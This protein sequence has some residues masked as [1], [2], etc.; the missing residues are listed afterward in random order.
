MKTL[1]RTLTLLALILFQPTVAPAQDAPNSTVDLANSANDLKTLEQFL[2]PTTLIVAQFDMQQLKLPDDLQKSLAENQTAQPLLA[3]LDS[4]KA[5]LEPMSNDR[6]Y[7]TF[8]I[9]ATPTMS[10]IRFFAK[11]SAALDMEKL[12][13]TLAQFRFSPAVVK[14]DFIVTSPAGNIVEDDKNAIT[15]DT[16]TAARPALQEALATVNGMPMQ[17]LLLPPD[18]LWATYRDLMPRLPEQLGGT[19]IATVTEGMKWAAIGIDPA[20]LKVKVTI[21]SNSKAAAAALATELPKLAQ[22]ASGQLPEGSAKTT[23]QAILK[24]GKPTV[25]DDRIEIDFSN[26]SELNLAS[27]AVA[28]LLSAIVDPLNTREKM[29]RFKQL[30]LAVHNYID[31]NKQFP[32]SKEARKADGTSNLSWRVHILPFIGEE[33]LYS[34]FKLDQS[35]DSELNIALL[36][37]MPEIFSGF[38]V[39]AFAPINL[40]QGHTTF[41]A[42]VGEGT[43]FGGVKPVTFSD[44][45]DGTSNTIMF[46][47]VKSDRAV[48]WTAPWDYTFNPANPTSDLAIGADGQFLTAFGDGSV[49]LLPGDM[50]KETLNHLFQMNDGN[51]INF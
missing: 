4:M 32:P 7:M 10:P 39:K 16:L 43:I 36:A 27:T 24:L 19:T 5:S 6:I 37:K 13:Q 15:S 51:A 38:P 28:K 45:T 22:V 31:A 20:K 29:N 35:W 44:I 3:W 2:T 26:L 8:D 41:V 50:P 12:N 48:P 33:K 34:E 18:Y 1:I 25:N 11:K 30:T 46:V 23:V 49:R 21:Q 14:G 42:P 9:P 47:E 40:R 17:I